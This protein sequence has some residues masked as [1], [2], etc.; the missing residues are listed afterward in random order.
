MNLEKFVLKIARVTC[1]MKQLNQKINDVLY[2]AVIRVKPYDGTRCLTL[3]GS[4]KNDTICNRS[5]YLISLNS[6]ITCVFSHY[7]AKIKVDCYDSLL[8]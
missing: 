2:E 3:F 5:R 7:Q 1:P 8:I 6:S 4:E